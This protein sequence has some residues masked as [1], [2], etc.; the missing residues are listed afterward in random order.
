M[1]SA[2]VENP[3]PA[4][5]ADGKQPKVA[6]LQVGRGAKPE[7]SLPTDRISLAK[8]LAILRAFD[9]ASGLSRMPVTL[10]EVGGIAELKPDTISM[11]MSFFVEAGL[12]RKTD[13][14]F[15]P[16]DAVHEF[17]LAND[18][19]AKTAPT[20]L[21]SALID[22]WFY[23]ELEPKLRFS[24]SLERDA[25]IQ[26]LALAVHAGPGYRA[27]IDLLLEFLEVAGVVQR[28]GMLIRVQRD[29]ENVKRVQD[30]DRSEST[31]TTVLP[32]VREERRIEFRGGGGSSDDKTPIHPAIVGLLRE[33]PTPGGSW[34]R[35][36]KDRFKAAFAS[37]LD[38]IYPTDD[39]EAH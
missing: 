17:A 1:E 6:Q 10:K 34:S 24:G 2:Q 7:R 3:T 25:A 28:D 38:V 32:P 14:G 26:Q 31:P 9:A 16:S 37:I 15:I 33:L 5:S 18:W 20:K 36:G 27:Q 30:G 12:I 22:S 4:V 8:Q 19:D 39:D 29:A 13:K 11:A 21:A 35:S 23:R